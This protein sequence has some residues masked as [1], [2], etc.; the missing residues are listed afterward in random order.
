MNSSR[1]CLAQWLNY[2]S[3]A[4]NIMQPHLR[5]EKSS[6]H[7]YLVDCL[8]L[9]MLDF[10]FIYLFSSQRPQKVF[11]ENRCTSSG[12]PQG[13]APSPLLFIRYTDDCRISP[14]CHPVS[15]R[16]LVSTLITQSDTTSTTPVSMSL[17]TGATN[18]ISS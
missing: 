5:Q 18:Q 8:V 9:W 17:L 7:D 15:D 4:F 1:R 11:S 16:V 3:Y 12:L 13:C 2:F 14:N 6:H 10:L